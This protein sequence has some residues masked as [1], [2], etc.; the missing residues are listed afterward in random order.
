MTIS[1]VLGAQW[2][3]EGG[4]MNSLRSRSRSRLLSSQDDIYDAIYMMNAGML[5]RGS[6]FP[7]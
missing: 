5:M 6:F 1:I 7:Y 3:D 4:G 2:G